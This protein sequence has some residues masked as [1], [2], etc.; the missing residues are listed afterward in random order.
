M[1]QIKK[2]DV[3]YNDNGPKGVCVMIHDNCVVALVEGNQI[4]SAHASTWNH[5]PKSNPDH[6]NR[7]IG[8][9]EDMELAIRV[10]SDRMAFVDRVLEK[11]IIQDGWDEIWQKAFDE[12]VEEMKNETN[13]VK[14]NA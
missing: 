11:I 6:P 12:V 13:P 5:N 1:K 14:E 3:I 10:Y 2:G 7:E 8:Y 9:L 4:F